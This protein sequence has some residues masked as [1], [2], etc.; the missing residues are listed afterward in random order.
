MVFHFKECD[1]WHDLKSMIAQKLSKSPDSVLITYR[2]RPVVDGDE[3][4]KTVKRNH[5]TVY[6][7]VHRDSFVKGRRAIPAVA[8]ARTGSPGKTAAT[9]PTSS[10]GAFKAHAATAGKR[11]HT[12]GKI[13]ANTGKR[14]GRIMFK[15]A[16][17]R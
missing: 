17:C 1:T 14:K 13:A 15:R 7:T 4:L 10:P 6:C 9:A 3:L 11:I 5:V 8:T 2:D 12:T 16:C